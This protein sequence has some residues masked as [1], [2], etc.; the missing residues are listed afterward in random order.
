MKCCQYYGFIH[1]SRIFNN[2]I[3]LI[4]DVVLIFIKGH[5]RYDMNLCYWKLKIIS[6]SWN[7]PS[8]TFKNSCPNLILNVAQNKRFKKCW[9]TRNGWKIL[10]T[11][12]KIY[13]IRKLTSR[14]IDSFVACMACSAVWNE[15]LV[16]I[17]TIQCRLW[18]LIISWGP[19]TLRRSKNVSVSRSVSTIFP[20]FQYLVDVYRFIFI[21]SV[22]SIC[23]ISKN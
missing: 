15:N 22:I 14:N 17:N 23:Q 11:Y 8:K 3:L 10:L 12:K 19:K 13:A 5:Y 6:F 4:M 9:I 21:W 20:P 16:Q 1:I 2:K 7:F 18:I